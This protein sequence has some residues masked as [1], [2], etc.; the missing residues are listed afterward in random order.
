MEKTTIYNPPFTALV[1][2]NPY[3]A[4]CCE[5]Y[6]VKSNGPKKFWIDWM[7]FCGRSQEMGNLLLTEKK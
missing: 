1:W 5:R 2:I 3:F 7:M 6:E 4:P